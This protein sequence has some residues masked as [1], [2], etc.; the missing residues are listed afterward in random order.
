MNFVTTLFGKAFSKR[1]TC[2]SHLVSLGLTSKHGMAILIWLNR[3]SAN[4]HLGE[5]KYIFLE[6]LWSLRCRSRAAN[7]AAWRDLNYVG[8]LPPCTSMPWTPELPQVFGRHSVGLRPL[9][10]QRPSGRWRYFHSHS[11]GPGPGPGLAPAGL[12]LARV[13]LARPGSGRDLAG[14][15]VARPGPCPADL[16]AG[17]C[18]PGSCPAGPWPGLAGLACP[19]GPAHVSY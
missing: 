17:S 9:S 12:A 6:C 11:P 4:S 8:L 13:A 10:R 14:L 7:A 5:P 18:R 2:F 3:I 15:A 19:M 16:W 1:N